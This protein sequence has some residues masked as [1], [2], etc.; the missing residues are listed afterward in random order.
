MKEKWI[1][2]CGSYTVE[3]AFLMPVI[4]FLLAFLLQLSIGWYE[5]VQKASEDTETICEME[6]RN[7]FLNIGE[8]ES[9]KD[10]LIP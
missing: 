5:S 3:A 10:M 2:L 6:T 9:V 7:Y 8:L 4:V 1:R